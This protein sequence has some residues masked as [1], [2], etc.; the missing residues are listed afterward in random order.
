MAI[1]VVFYS[2]YFSF[3]TFSEMNLYLTIFFLQTN[4]FDLFETFFGPSMGGFAGMDPAGFGTRRRSTITK[5]QD[6]R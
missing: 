6:I 4:P 2:I 3:A 5:G 1:E